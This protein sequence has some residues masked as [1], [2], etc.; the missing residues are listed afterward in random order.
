M[1]RAERGAGPRGHRS[2]ARRAQGGLGSRRDGA[3]PASLRLRASQPD[4]DVCG[5]AQTAGEASKA[6]RDGFSTY[7]LMLRRRRRR[8]VREANLHVELKGNAQPI[9]RRCFALILRGVVAAGEELL[10]GTETLEGQIERAESGAEDGAAAGGG[11]GGSGGAATGGADDGEQL[12]EDEIFE[13]VED[14]DL[15]EAR[16][17]C[18]EEGI[19]AEGMDLD[20]M[21]AELIELMTEQAASAGGGGSGGGGGGGGAAEVD[22]DIAEYIEAI[23]EMD[24]EEAVEACEEEGIDWE[25]ME[26]L[27]ELRQALIQ[28]F[29]G[30]DAGGAAAGGAADGESAEDDNFYAGLIAEMDLATA[31][32][33]AEDEGVELADDVTLPQAKSALLAHFCPGRAGSGGSGGMQWLLDLEVKP[34]EIY[35]LTF[36][37][38]EE[39]K[40]S[41]T[42]MGNMASTRVS[43]VAAMIAASVEGVA[44]APARHDFDS[45]SSSDSGA[46]E[47]A[48]EPEPAPAARAGTVAV[49]AQLLR[50]LPDVE[51]VDADGEAAIT[52]EQARQVMILLKPYKT[53]GP[54]AP[55]QF[56]PS[57]CAGLR[58]IA[59]IGDDYRRVIGQNDGVVM[60]ADWLEHTAI[61]STTIVVCEVLASL[62]TLHANVRSFIAAHGLAHLFRVLDNVS[63]RSCFPAA[64]EVLAKIVAHQPEDG[65]IA[66]IVISGAGEYRG[67]DALFS[68]LKSE[69]TPDFL[70]KVC[71]VLFFLT[72][73]ELTRQ[74][75]VDPSSG[76]M[77]ILGDLLHEYIRE[78]EVS[79]VEHI[80][81]VWVQLGQGHEAAAVAK[82]LAEQSVLAD[83]KKAFEEFPKEVTVQQCLI[84]LI[85]SMGISSEIKMAV[86]FSKLLDCIVKAMMRFRGKADPRFAEIQEQGC[87]AINAISKGEEKIKEYLADRQDELHVMEAITE[88]L[89]NFKRDEGLALHGCSAVWSVAFK[90][91][92]MKNRA[93]EVGVFPTIIE[94]IMAHKRNQKL[95]PH[96]LVAIGNL[97]A[98]HAPNQALC[99]QE[100]V[101]DMCLEIMPLHRKEPTIM[102]TLLSCLNS[103]MAEQPDNIAI[104]NEGNGKAMV[105]KVQRMH[106]D[107]KVQ[108]LS[109][110]VLGCVE[111]DAQ[112]AKERAKQRR[113]GK[114]KRTRSSAVAVT[115]RN[116]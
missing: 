58:T 63:R 44:M 9:R 18:E 104:F 6:I 85:A 16:A 60:L 8:L 50:I 70:V 28:H 47:P 37:G 4:P 101:V 46:D 62:C 15:D 116:L 56:V 54:A 72:E 7:K 25:E 5:R 22:P 75:V 27:T 11:A 17:S 110:N 65:E 23:K 93:G 2:A 102:Y 24:E 45:E 84:A 20:D 76:Y 73:D 55:P 82:F 99:G 97:S 106:D 88:A 34:A 14:M 61:D 53:G 90:N 69:P 107:A 33:A 115:Y 81:S 42:T 105:E 94:L 41:L 35:P 29:T 40:G 91:V 103:V 43:S 10:E 57:V 74:Q 64:V 86:A 49:V 30:G 12:T 21:K 3:H 114:P 89:Q 48:P 109:T 80:C 52:V 78:H 67:L 113:R 100:G 83:L 108:Q 71:R 79:A 19:D 36:S 96:A 92:R 51:L 38:D 95:L 26:G 68:S 31:L 66:T 77:R 59:D 111:H 1:R 13:L 32:S 39:L 112:Q 87:R 98:N